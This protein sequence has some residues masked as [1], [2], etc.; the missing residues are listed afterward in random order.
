[1]PDFISRTGR[2]VVHVHGTSAGERW[3]YRP[4]AGVTAFRPFDPL[5]RWQSG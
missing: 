2:G 4:V 3:F 5:N 1:M